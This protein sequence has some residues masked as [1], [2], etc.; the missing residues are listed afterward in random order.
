MRNVFPLT[1]WKITA[2]LL[3]ILLWFYDSR[4]K[5]HSKKICNLTRSALHF[6]FVSFHSDQLQEKTLLLGS[7]FN[8]RLLSSIRFLHNLFQMRWSKL[9][10]VVQSF[11][12]EIVIWQLIYSPTSLPIVFGFRHAKKQFSIP[13]SMS[14]Q[15]RVDL[16]EKVTYL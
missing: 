4:V 10:T 13:Q 3:L 16:V 6:C 14:R 9:Y 12:A 15:M 5:G 1:H 2:A 8:S 11:S 7:F